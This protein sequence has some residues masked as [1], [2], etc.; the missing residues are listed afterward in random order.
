MH[1]EHCPGL[2]DLQQARKD[3]VLHKV[4]EVELFANL[5]Q[6]RDLVAAYALHGT[7]QATSSLEELDET[8]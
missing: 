6:M 7:G 3:L 5:G 1:P 2:D 8:C 4:H